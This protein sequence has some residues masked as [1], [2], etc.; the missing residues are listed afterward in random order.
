MP[1]WGADN[2]FSPQQG[3]S[4]MLGAWGRQGYFCLY[5][6]GSPIPMLIFFYNKAVNPLLY[7]AHHNRHL[8]DL[9][10]WQEL[11]FQQGDPVLELGCGTGRLLI[12]LAEAGYRL[13]GLDREAGML[14]ELQAHLPAD[15]GGRV[16]L[17][18]TDFLSMPLAR[19]FPLII[20]PC[21]TLSTLPRRV[22]GSFF[23]RVAAS[24]AAGG[25]FAASLPNPDLLADLNP[26]GEPAV[27]EIITH[28]ETGHPIQVSSAWERVGDRVTFHWIY[29]HLLPDGQVEREQFSTQHELMPLADYRAALEAS[30]LIVHAVYGD[31]DRSPHSPESPYL[32]FLAGLA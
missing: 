6:A 20:L 27:E 14:A 10:F 8:E 31:T 15:C 3:L 13:V 21:N 7:H 5:R 29:D 16:H 11:V 25:I 30:G 1:A 26:L 17:V 19:R 32:I 18:Q 9:P 24:L 4:I 2:Q 23:Q 22:V 12:P 28:P